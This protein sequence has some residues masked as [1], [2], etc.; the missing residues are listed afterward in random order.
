MS[1]TWKLLDLLFFISITYNPTNNPTIVTEAKVLILSIYNNLTIEIHPTVQRLAVDHS[2]MLYCI[3][4]I[5]HNT[6][7]PIRHRQH[8]KLDATH[9]IKIYSGIREH[10][11][12]CI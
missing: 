8:T 12:Q 11:Q 9:N 6:L 2:E 7:Y 3:W 5:L 4:T 1:A 10:S